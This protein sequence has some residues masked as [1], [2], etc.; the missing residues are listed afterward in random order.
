MVEVNDRVVLSDECIE[1]HLKAF[2]DKYLKEWGVDMRGFGEGLVVDIQPCGEQVLHNGEWV[3]AFTAIVEWEN[4][5]ILNYDG[6]EDKLLN[7]IGLQWLAKVES[8]A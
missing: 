2:G 1:H 3:D 5:Q 6:E 8:D 4:P 7:E